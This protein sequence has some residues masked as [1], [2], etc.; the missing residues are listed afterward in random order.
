MNS[1]LLPPALKSGFP[2][3][4]IFPCL[5]SIFWHQATA[6]FQLL[7]TKIKAYSWWGSLLYTGL[8]I[9]HIKQA[10]YFNDYWMPSG[11]EVLAS[12]NV[13]CSATF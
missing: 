11:T 3:A 12:H 10:S 1:P 9:L 8:H 6:I 4:Y 7:F 2:S 5:F 13:C